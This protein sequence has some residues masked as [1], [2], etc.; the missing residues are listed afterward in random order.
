MNP[1]ESEQE[2]PI[3]IQHSS[4]NEKKMSATEVWKDI[5]LEQKFVV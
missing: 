1:L 5:E 4:F 2:S 3:A